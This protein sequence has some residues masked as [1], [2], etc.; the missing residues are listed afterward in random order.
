M[1][2]LKGKI[3]RCVIFGDIQQPIWQGEKVAVTIDWKEMHTKPPS[4]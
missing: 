2:G 1:E 4:K 3:C